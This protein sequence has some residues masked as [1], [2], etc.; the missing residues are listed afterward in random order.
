MMDI[1]ANPK[2]IFRANSRSFSLAASFFRPSDQKAV[3]RLYRFCRYLDDLAD[4]TLDGDIVALDLATARLTRNVD[5]P[6]DSV[7]ADFIALSDERSIPM[8]P[9]LILLK[10]LRDDCGSRSI[11]T[12]EELVQFA[13]GVAGTVGQMLRYVIDAKNPGADA[14]AID[15]G[16]ALQ[17]SNVMRDIA[18]DAKRGRFY[19]PA[20]WVTPTTVLEAIAGQ[21]DA[22]RELLAAVAQTHALAEGYYINATKGM[23]HIP[24]RN[25]RVIFFASTLYR[26]IGNKVLRVGM[27]SLSKR[28]I[29]TFPEK[30]RLGWYTLHAYRHW[31]RNHWKSNPEPIHNLNNA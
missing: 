28:T 13:Y 20:E 17:L 5:V 18:E 7:E 26:E 29:V 8:E 15:L 11:Q 6:A 23:A 14:F 12:S 1:H 19:L 22:I 10:A 3:A 4:D 24:A 27:K 2:V 30:I 16:V 9:A 25:R 21:E 31:R